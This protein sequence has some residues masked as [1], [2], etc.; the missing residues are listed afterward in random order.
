LAQILGQLQASDRDFSQNVGPSRT[1]RAN[2][3]KQS[4]LRGSRPLDRASDSAAR[5]RPV[6][7]HTGPASWVQ[8]TGAP[9][10]PAQMRA[11]AT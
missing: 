10:P 8:R 9:P 5:C 2:P 7:L 3:V 1:I 11:W 6:V 4:P